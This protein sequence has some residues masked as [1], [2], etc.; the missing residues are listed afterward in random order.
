MGTG[1]A[2][3]E[4]SVVA[5]P[6][7]AGTIRVRMTVEVEA[8]KA[9]WDENKQKHNEH[10]IFFPSCVLPGTPKISPSWTKM[11]TRSAKMLQDELG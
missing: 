5:C 2:L 3:R 1:S 4:E 7:N 10:A 8:K 11:A 6:E 9:T